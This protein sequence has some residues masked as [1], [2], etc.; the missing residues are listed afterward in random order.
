[1]VRSV[2]AKAK[3]AAKR[4]TTITTT[5][6]GSTEAHT[7]L[8]N[9]CRLWLSDHGGLAI[10]NNTGQLFTGRGTM[11][12]FGLKG[13]SDIIACWR[14]RFLAVECKTGGAVLS[15]QQKLFKAAV[16]R[17][18]GLHVTARSTKDLEALT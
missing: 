16:L 1:V 13:S 18:G 4:K 3:P 14:G 2:P 15:D 5:P 11:V 6:P 9:E 8:V 12:A 17:A 7:K 10:Q